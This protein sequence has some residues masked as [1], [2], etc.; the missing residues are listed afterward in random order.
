MSFSLSRLVVALGAG[1]LACAAQAGE[2]QVAAA[3]NFTAPM[4]AIAAQFEKDTGHKLNISFGSTGKFYSQIHNGAPYEVFLSADATTPEKLEK[5]GA[6]VAGS[7]FT[8]AI[9]KL[10]LWSAKPGYVDEQGEVLKKAEFQHLALPNPKLAPYGAAAIE[11]M[12]GMGLLE[13]AQPKFVLG[14][15]L[16]QAYQFVVSG[17]AELGFLALAQIM[18]DGK[19]IEGSTW[20]VPADK[21]APIRQDAVALAGAAKNPAATALLE[22]LK[23]EKARETIRSFGYDL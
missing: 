16:P 1:L 23:S 10:V 13:A 9:G 5:E 11:V 2:V 3:A 17:N 22:Y 14:E 19:L 20:L 6:T 21:Y 15:N 4:Q 18:K 7:R 12:R 8:Y